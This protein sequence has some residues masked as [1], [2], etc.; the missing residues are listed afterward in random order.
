MVAILLSIWA[1]IDTTIPLS[2][3]DSRLAMPYTRDHAIDTSRAVFVDAVAATMWICWVTTWI[4][5]RLAHKY[6]RCLEHA[7]QRADARLL[8]RIES[9]LDKRLMTLAERDAEHER[10]TAERDDQRGQSALALV[11]AVH[12]LIET[13]MRDGDERAA[14]AVQHAH[15]QLGRLSLVNVDPAST[16]PSA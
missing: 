5:C 13:L 3:P 12:T 2:V 8:E 6:Q 16:R 1:L 9:I 10:V 7:R 11:G 14:L 4:V 15:A